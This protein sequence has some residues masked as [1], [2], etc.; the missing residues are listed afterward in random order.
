MAIWMQ[1]H[2][3]MWLRAVQLPVVASWTCCLYPDGQAG[4]FTIAGDIYNIF[5]L[6]GS[7]VFLQPVTHNT[8]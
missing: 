4:L 7:A 5:C 1:E 3:Q 8:F 2:L 6:Q